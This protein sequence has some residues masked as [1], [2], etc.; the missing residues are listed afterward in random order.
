MTIWAENPEWML[1]AFKL[2]LPCAFSTGHLY[3]C[4]G[5][6]RPSK[7][8]WCKKTLRLTCCLLVFN[9]LFLDL[10]HYNRHF[11]WGGQHGMTHWMD[12]SK[13]CGP[14]CATTN[15]FWDEAS[16]LVERSSGIG[17]PQT[18]IWTKSPLPA[19][20]GEMDQPPWWLPKGWQVLHQQRIFAPGITDNNKWD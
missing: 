16:R 7:W 4:V 5:S 3:D 1:L 6:T 14:F 10:M 15:V 18:W 19:E 9:S 12:R 13:T 20:V 8:N 2:A 11:L 17:R